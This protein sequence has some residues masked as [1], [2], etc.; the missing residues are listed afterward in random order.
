VGP[1][2]RPVGSIAIEL[3]DSYTGTRKALRPRTN[4]PRIA[5]PGEGPMKWDRDDGR[6]YVTGQPYAD[7]FR[8]G[9]PGGA[10]GGDGR[11]RSRWP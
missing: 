6:R 3:G 7:N 2:A 1:G 11:A 8:L 5:K 9:N 4:R 10:G